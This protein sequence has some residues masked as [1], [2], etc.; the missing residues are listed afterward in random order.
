[1]HKCQK[2]KLTIG[3]N[4]DNESKENLPKSDWKC[5]QTNHENLDEVKKKLYVKLIRKEKRLMKM[6]MLNPK[7]NNVS[8]QRK[9]WTQFVETRMKV[10]IK[11]LSR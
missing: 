11:R 6:L 3:E 7:R 8:L 9:E 2:R 10:E 4:L 5:E 1:M